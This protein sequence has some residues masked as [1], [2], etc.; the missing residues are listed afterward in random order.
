MKLLDDGHRAEAS[1]VSPPDGPAFQRIATAARAT[2][3]IE[4][5][6]VAPYLVVGGTDRYDWVG[7]TTAYADLTANGTKNNA[8]NK[9]HASCR[10]CVRSQHKTCWQ[11]VLP[12]AFPLIAASLHFLNHVSSCAA[13]TTRRSQ[14]TS[15]ASSQWHTASARAT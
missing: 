10:C 11:Q 3:G 15:T 12:P 1:V 4:G 5:L 8:Q 9:L 7:D 14:T 13:N 6:V 2:M